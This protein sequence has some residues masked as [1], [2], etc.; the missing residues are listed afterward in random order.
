MTNREKELRT[1]LD[2]IEENFPEPFWKLAEI[3]ELQALEICEA[4]NGKDIL[5][6]YMMND[7]VENY[8]ILRN[9]RIT[10]EYFPEANVLHPAKLVRE[11]V[12]DGQDEASYILSIRQ[13]EGNIFLMRFSAL[14]E[15][16]KCY[17]Y[18]RIGHFWV[19]GQEQWRQLV[20]IV[21]IIHD[22]YEYIGENICNDAEKELMPLIEF[23]P[24]R[25]WSPLRE[26][27]DSKYPFTYEGIDAIEQ[28][29]KEAGDSGYARLVRIYRRVPCKMLR[30]ILRRRLD[31]PRSEALYR[32]IRQKVEEASNAYSE[33][34]YEKGLQEEISRKRM[35]VDRILH[36]KG[37]RGIYPE[38]EKET[39][40]IVVTEE[41]P[42]TKEE[43]EYDDY[44]FRM[45]FMVSEMKKKRQ[46]GYLSGFFSGKGRIGWIAEAVEELK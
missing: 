25:D 6:P 14:E 3:L 29:A 30:E 45:K 38:Y 36:E 33:R 2:G 7:A 43:F 16:M 37:Y 4:R 46:N 40:Q 26:S 17:Q 13:D 9:C 12:A 22:K 20:Y 28:F 34:E 19:K 35:E 11:V 31:S 21:G 42:F 1:Y 8:L 5:I 24:F 32:R 23:P 15:R 44:T 39:T 27:L 18:H 10:G 41:Q